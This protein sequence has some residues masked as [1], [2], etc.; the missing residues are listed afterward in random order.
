MKA[1]NNRWNDDPE[2]NGGEDRGSSPGGRIW[3]HLLVIFILTIIFY[4]LFLYGSQKKEYLEIPYSAFKAELAQ[5][6]IKEVIARSEMISGEFFQAISADNSLPSAQERSYRYFSTR[7]PKFGDQ[8]LMRELIKAGATVRTDSGNEWILSLMIFVLP[9]LLILGFFWYTSRKLNSSQTALFTRFNKSGASLYKKTKSNI[10]FDDVAGLTNAKQELM[11]IVSYLKEPKKYERL[12]GKIPRGVLLMGPPGT[13]KTL[14]ARAVAG[15]ANV[16]FYSISGSQFIEMF[17]G[18]GASRVRDLFGKAKKNAPSIIFIDEIDSVGRYRGAGLG[19]GQDEREQTLNQILAEMDGFGEHHSVVVIAATNRPDV[20]DPAL[21]RP[22]RFDR[23]VVIERPHR[24][25]RLQILKVHTRKVRLA[26]DVNLELLAQGTP[27]FSGA[28]LENLVNE[29][30]I[31]AARQNK[32]QVYMED[33]EKAKDK[34][35]LGGLRED[36]LSEEEKRIVAYH[37]AGHTLVA[38]S[39]PDSD[40][41]HKVTIIP[42]GRSLGATEQLPKEEQHNYFQSYLMHRLAI[43]L[44]GRAAEQLV[45]NDITSGAEND[46]K[47]ATQLARRMVC[48]WGMSS[49]LGPVAFRHGE[50]HVF[51]GKE[52]AQEKDYSERTA[53]IIDQE[54]QSLLRAAL[55]QAEEILKENRK[56]L[57]RLAKALIEKEVLTEAE[58][59]ALIAEEKKQTEVQKE[60]SKLLVSQ[61]APGSV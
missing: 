51:L 28:D 18:V 40:P 22:G 27:G 2:D 43:N 19:G 17:V 6:N 9:W 55:Q 59:T 44:G 47:Q 52:I 13:G 1:E 14:I 20:L 58:I 33:L 57:D 5:K 23:Q 50:G 31:D 30:A 38:K 46:L 54:V 35:I 36:L 16:P 53:V 29:A 42:R 26:P 39:F 25:G 4:E 3:K 24:E 37:E 60:E 45:F 10:T 21:I 48:H 61:D 34:I 11:D 32:D 8:D 49:R 41:I 56:I 12:G 7:I 15:E